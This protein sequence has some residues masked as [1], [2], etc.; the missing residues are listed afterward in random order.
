MIALATAPT[1]EVPTL[2]GLSP[3]EL[4]DYYWASKGVHVVRQGE[5]GEIPADAEQYLLTDPRTLATFR[6][7]GLVD[8]LSWVRPQVLFVRL[9]VAQDTSYRER[10]V[11]DD[12]DQFVAFRRSYTGLGSRFA[13]LVLTR[14]RRVAELWRSAPDVQSAWR[15]LRRATR[16]AVREIAST[17]GRMYDR[18]DDASLARFVQDLI[19]SWHNPAST[20]PHLRRAR[21]NVWG[22]EQAKVGAAVRFIGPVWIGAGRS[23]DGE[24]NV[25]GPA[26]LWDDPAARPLRRQV[27]WGT[28]EPAA[29]SVIVRQVH[30]RRSS[31]LYTLLRRAFDILFA[32]L[33][34]LTTLPIY[35]LVMFAIWLED[36]R[37][38]F[39]AHRRETVGGREF[40]CI[41]FRSMRKDADQIKAKLSSHN[42]A[43]GPQFFIERDPRLT[44]VGRIIRKC[45]L[46]ELPQFFNVLAGDMSVVG[47]RPSPRK[48]N[49]YCPPWREARLSVKPGITGL[50]QVKRT[51][52]QGLDF[53][54][55]IKYDIEYVENLGWRLDLLIIFQ[56]FWVLLRGVVRA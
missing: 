24:R 8:L 16:H 2:W 1:P 56:T 31:H 37:P 3:T 44:R 54:E 25:V 53:Q 22:H 40:L 41:K 45:N 13:R 20:V 38:F 49:Q 52:R 21:P 55:W 42:Q 10:A 14:D 4:H 27:A 28:I 7:R 18:L 5:D 35:P 15:M 33:V 30:P 39:F 48:E 46:D 9:E 50:W 34:I 36:G 6:L 17:K 19:Q 32:A 11:A 23:I 29:P 51:R 47:P 43:D 12:S 26:A